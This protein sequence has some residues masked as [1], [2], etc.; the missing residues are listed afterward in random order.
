LYKLLHAASGAPMVHCAALDHANLLLVR[1][2][3]QRITRQNPGAEG[4]VELLPTGQPSSSLPSLQQQQQQRAGAAG[5][6]KHSSSTAAAAAA[7]EAA[8]AAAIAAL[9]GSKKGTADVSG[10]K[11][12]ASEFDN[13]QQQQAAGVGDASC[14]AAA[15]G[16]HWSASKRVPPATR[17]Y[18]RTPGSTPGLDSDAM[19]SDSD[20]EAEQ[21]DAAAHCAAADDT[22]AA[23]GGVFRRAGAR[24]QARK[25]VVRRGAKAAGTCG[26]QRAPAF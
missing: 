20:T 16:V 4:H 5:V 14:A 1:V 24:A 10:S 12:P 22:A 8:V 25:G 18:S 7:V 17:G 15:E 26:P 6:R 13:A 19:Q 2:C 23:V 21:E 3:L 11:R 9:G